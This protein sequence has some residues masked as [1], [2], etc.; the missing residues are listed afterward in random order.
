MVRLVLILITFFLPANLAQAD[1]QVRGRYIAGQ[2]NRVSLHISVHQPVPA[3][4]IVIQ[5]MAPGV[6]LIAATPPP[7]GRQ[8]DSAVKWLFKRPRPGQLVVNM[9]FAQPVAL[10]QLEG[11]IS[12]RHP[13]NG[14]L[15]LSS[16]GE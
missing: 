10:N 5:K 1:S 9:Q 16:I 4:F 3:A 15:V 2:E 11:S 8:G 12:Y 13:E 14:S 7:I 6:S